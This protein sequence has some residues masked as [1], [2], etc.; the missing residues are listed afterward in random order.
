[1]MQLQRQPAAGLHQDALDLIAVAVVERVIVAPRPMHGDVILGD[2][3]SHLLQPVHELPH[4]VDVL[5]VGHQNRILAR[6]HHEILDP[7][8]AHQRL[9]GGGVGA[10][11]VDKHRAC[12]ARHCPPNPCPRDPTPPARS[13][14]PTS[15]RRPARR[16][17]AWSSP[18]PHSRP[19]LRWRG[20]KS[21]ALSVMKPRSRTG[22][23]DRGGDRGGAL[24]IEAAIF[25]DK[26]R[27]PEHQIAGVP[28][29]AVARD[30]C[31]PSPRRAFRRTSRR[32]TRRRAS[33]L[34]R[35]I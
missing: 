12:P 22:A 25:V 32:R 24:G 14:R 34:P 19:I 11:R 17:R 20:A 33:I 23:F 27:A 4:A 5:S 29:I 21:S 7:E 31:A 8:Q 13:R 2:A 35:R 1:M 16:R 3:G 28:Q 6:H 15:H 30:S 18:S 10:L 26:T 9:V